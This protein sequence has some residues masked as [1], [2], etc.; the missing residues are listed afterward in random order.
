MCATI[1]ASPMRS[2]VSAWKFA[3][4][5][6]LIPILMAYSTIMVLDGPVTDLVVAV[7][8]S[9]VALAA[10]AIAI[11]G[12]FLRRTLVG[13][14]VAL[15]LAA[16]LIMVAPEWSALFA[17]ALSTTVAPGVFVG[18]GSALG[19]VMIGLQVVHHLRNRPRQGGTDSAPAEA[20]TLG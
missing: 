3:K 11:E 7:A 10:S 14:R 6:Y 15:I 1:T 17:G 4:G 8:S 18:A 13:E 2:G 5:L 20:A 19:V 16:A 12:H 9:C